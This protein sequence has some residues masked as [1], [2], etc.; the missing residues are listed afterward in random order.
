MENKYTKIAFGISLVI[1]VIFGF[2]L[3]TYSKRASE[4]RELA[5]SPIAWTTNFQEGIETAKTNNKPV[6]LNFTASWC[7]P[8]K[9][10]AKTTFQDPKV[11][12][13]LEKFEAIKIDVD[14]NSDIVQ[15]FGVRPIP[16]YIIISAKGDREE[17]VGYKSPEEFAEILKKYQ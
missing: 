12:S 1:G 14:Q 6:L 3:I 7:P 10:M 16:T 5:N 11:A 4:N 15:T 13:L 2:S 9:Q 8:C 17:H